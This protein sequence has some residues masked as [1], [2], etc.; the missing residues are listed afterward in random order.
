MAVRGY[1]RVLAITL[2]TG[3]GSAFVTGH[4]TEVSEG[5]LYRQPFRDSIVD[6]YI[7]RRGILRLAASLGLPGWADVADLAHNALSGDEAC[8]RLFNEW[9]ELLAEALAPAIT[10]FRPDC[11]A[12]GDAIGRSLA[13]FRG[14]IDRLAAGLAGPGAGLTIVPAADGHSAVRGAAESARR[15]STWSPI[16]SQRRNQEFGE[17][18]VS[19]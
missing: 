1:S 17:G 11:I 8:L 13:L 15:L 3:C 10:S 4:G 18:N 12:L 14:P 5:G 16:N 6:N 19:S 7:S 9:G 2:G